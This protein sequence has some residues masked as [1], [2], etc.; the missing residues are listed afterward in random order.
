MKKLKRGL[1]EQGFTDI[2]EENICFNIVTIDF[3][4]PLAFCIE[5]DED[6]IL[7]VCTTH[8]GKEEVHLIQ[9]KHIVFCHIVYNA[10]DLVETEEE[11]SKN[12][13][14]FW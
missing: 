10:E 9:K 8:D 6:S 13:R 5:E 1:E 11:G 7:V 4:L 14:M 12:D 3:T 2:P